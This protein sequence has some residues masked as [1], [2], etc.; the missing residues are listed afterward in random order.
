MFFSGGARAVVARYTAYIILE[1]LAFFAQ[2]VEHAA[3]VTIVGHAEFTAESGGEF[4]YAA[5]MFGIGLD[6]PL[7]CIFITVKV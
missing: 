5:A 7:P 1:T 2:I 6:C 3:S 4:G